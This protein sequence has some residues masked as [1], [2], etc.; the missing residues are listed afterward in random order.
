MSRSTDC[1]KIER[2]RERERERQTDRQT[3]RLGLALAFGTSK[4]SDTLPITRAHLLILR[5]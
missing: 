4:P 1:K 3:D 5:K 2:E